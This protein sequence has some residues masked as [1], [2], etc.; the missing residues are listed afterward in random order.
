MS[1]QNNTVFGSVIAVNELEF[2]IEII[3]YGMNYTKDLHSQVSSN[4]SLFTERD[5]LM[6]E[7]FDMN[8]KNYADEEK[9]FNQDDGP[10]DDFTSS[11]NKKDEYFLDEEKVVYRIGRRQKGQ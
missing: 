9:N 8:Y 5:V 1:F 11:D 7:V 10:K 6:R 2:S 4:N 3:I